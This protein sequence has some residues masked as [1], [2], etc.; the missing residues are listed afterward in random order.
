[1]Y[2]LRLYSQLGEKKEEKKDEKKDEKTHPILLDL[3]SSDLD[4]GVQKIRDFELSVVDTQPAVIGGANQEFIFSPRIDNLLSCFTA[5]D[6]SLK[7][8][9]LIF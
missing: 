6:V 4:C 3:L 5:L 8:I 7:F 1:M 9:L 2:E